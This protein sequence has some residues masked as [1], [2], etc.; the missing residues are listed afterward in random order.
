VA[1]EDPSV[2]WSPF[3]TLSGIRRL[4]PSQVDG[5]CTIL[6]ATKA[7]SEFTSLSCEVTQITNINVAT[8][9]GSLRN[10]LAQLPF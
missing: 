10:C 4:Q 5:S 2:N 3:Y 1:L 6:L 7:M 9:F 8:T